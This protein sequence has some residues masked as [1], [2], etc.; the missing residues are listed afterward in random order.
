VVAN[1]G[2]GEEDLRYFIFD[3]RF[4]LFHVDGGFALFYIGWRI[5]AILYS[6]ADLRYFIFDGGGKPRRYNGKFK[7]DFGTCGACL[8]QSKTE[9][10]IL[11]TPI[12]YHERNRANIKTLR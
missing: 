5:C 11:I 2:E 1:I 8:R 4:A 3:G 10:W 9:Q 7:K 6:M 12:V